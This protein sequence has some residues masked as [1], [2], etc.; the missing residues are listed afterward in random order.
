MRGRWGV[1]LLAVVGC[2]DAPVEE[3]ARTVCGGPST[4]DELTLFGQLT[5]LSWWA[6]GPCTDGGGL[7]PTCNRLELRRDGSYAWTAASDYLERDDHGAW[8]FRARDARS[9][10]LCLGDGSV[11]DFALEPTGLRFGPLGILDP[12]QPL[13]G[14][15]SRDQLPTVRVDDAYVALTAHPWVKTNELDLYRL[16]EELALARDGTLAA[17]YRSGSCEVTGTF[18]LV[19][20]HVGGLTPRTRFSL[21]PAEAP[22]TC[23]LR[24]GGSPANVP[25]GEPELEGDL[26]HFYAASYRPPGPTEDRLLRFSYGSDA[27]LAITARWTGALHS[28]APSAWT[29]DLVNNDPLRAQ[30]LVR[31]RLAQTPLVATSDSYQA[32]GPE[33]VLADVAIGQTLAPGASLELPVT[34]TLGAPG[35]TQLVILAESGPAGGSTYRTQ[36]GFLADLP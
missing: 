6:S 20:D 29:F 4:H 11:I 7:P 28:N 9:G 16:P 26:L 14:T 12:D 31:L 5:A 19:A 27:G 17:T 1:I 2:T 8:N 13:G 32:A 33:V 34:F 15:G 23:D 25:S 22:N 36:N 3:L 24:G 18:S 10:V 21:W 35:L 30:Q